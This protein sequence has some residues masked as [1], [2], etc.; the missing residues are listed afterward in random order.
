MQGYI[1]SL[2]QIKD[3]DLLVTILTSSQ[4]L[5]TYRFYGA[6]HS[7]INIGYKIDFEIEQ[8]KANIPRLKDVLQ[9][10]FSWILDYEK[11]Y[12]WQ[13]FIQ[14][15]YTHLKDIEEID[16][17]Y[18]DNL[19]LLV[20]KMTK[21]NTLRAICEAYINLLEYE[22][23]L[24]KDYECLLCEKEIKEDISLVRSFIPVHSKCSYSRTF[25]IKKIKELFE[26]KSLIL[27]DDDE[28]EYLWNILLQGL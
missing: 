3:D 19:D 14:L 18:F 9:I 25:E 10:G 24:H 11:M 2:K 7:N 13:R 22:G 6:R 4:V 26:N 27:F 23:R 17:F 5:T 12:A 20:Y 8:T 16:S 1:I 28:V 21:Q 15:F